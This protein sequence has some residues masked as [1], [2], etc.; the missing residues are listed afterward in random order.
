MVTTL[1]A[2]PSVSACREFSISWGTV[3]SQR[4]SF[5]LSPLTLRGRSCL[6]SLLPLSNQDTPSLLV[7]LSVP[8]FTTPSLLPTSLLIASAA[9]SQSAYPGTSCSPPLRFWRLSFLLLFFV[10]IASSSI[11]LPAAP[12]RFDPRLGPILHPR[13]DPPFDSFRH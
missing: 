7:I 12:L 10:S 8:F 4:P 13:L 1:S 11:A 2:L 3:K 5:Q 9:L 6:P